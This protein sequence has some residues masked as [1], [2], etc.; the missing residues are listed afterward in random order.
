VSRISTSKKRGLDCSPSY[1]AKD[2]ILYQLMSQPRRFALMTY[3]LD[4]QRLRWQDQ[5]FEVASSL[6]LDSEML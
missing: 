3:S 5:A 4:T 6:Q 1:S 2:Y